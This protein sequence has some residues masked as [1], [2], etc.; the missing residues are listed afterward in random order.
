MVKNAWPFSLKAFIIVQKWKLIGN[1]T[2]GITVTPV[3]E[4]DI[5]IYGI[6]RP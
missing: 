3:T 5:E 4:S 6:L 1:F 2:I